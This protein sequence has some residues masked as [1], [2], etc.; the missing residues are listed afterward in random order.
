LAGARDGV[1][2]PEL[3]SSVEIGAVDEAADAVFAAGA[4]DDRH[5]AHDQRRRGYRLGDRRIGDLALPDDLAGRLVGGNEPA[6]ECDRD[7]LVL[8]Q[9]HAAVVD[10]AAGD[11]TGPGLVGL[12]IHA[13]LDGTLLAARD[14][15]GIDRAPAVGHI[16][17]AVLN[18]RG[19]LQ[20][21]VLVAGAGA[22][23]AAQRD[24]E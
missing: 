8:P 9:R 19:G 6:V 1:G 17:D 21:A 13:P 5:V 3:L 12:G 14:V 4:A 11:V 18:D 22:L 23:D 7:H 2:A 10:T 24:A 15:D 20:I 16:H